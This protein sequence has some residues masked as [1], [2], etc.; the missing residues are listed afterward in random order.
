VRNDDS[1]VLVVRIGEVAVVLPGDVGAEGE[2]AARAL[3]EP[4]RH[5]VLKAAHH[6]SATSSTGPFL[7]AL[8]PDVAVFSAGRANRF[9]HPSPSVVARYR[10]R[11]VPVFNTATDGA[12]ILETDGTR[13]EIAGWTGRNRVTLPASR[14]STPLPSR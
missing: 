6:G 4:A 12:V 2:S 5:V 9:G 10:A 3:F 11:G 7:D 1:V 13:V 14:A 8:R